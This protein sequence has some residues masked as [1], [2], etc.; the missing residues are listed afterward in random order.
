MTTHTTIK[1]MDVRFIN[2]FVTSLVSVFYE[3]VDVR[4]EKGSLVKGNGRKIFSGYGVAIGITGDIQGQVLF[5]FPENFSYLIT[6]ILTD[7]KR[8][9]YE[10]EE[11]EDMTRSVINEIGNTISAR[12]IT[13]LE[14]DKIN[15]DITPPVLYFGE[16]IQ[17]I[18]KNL[19][20]VIIPFKSNIGFVTVNIAMDM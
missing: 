4:M 1:F 20:T 8:G 18:P 3:M 6:E 13:R 19:K 12:A 16:E 11:L 2:P 15:C 9:D 5:E 17:I 14:Q 7:K 10:K